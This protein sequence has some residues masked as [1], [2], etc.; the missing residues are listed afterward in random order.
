[1]ARRWA[2]WGDRWPA[3]GRLEGVSYSNRSN[4]T[5]DRGLGQRQIEK[6]LA[7][8]ETP[9]RNAPFEHIFD[10]EELFEQENNPIFC[11]DAKKKERL[12]RLYRDGR[13]WTTAPQQAFDHDFPSWSE[14]V[15]IPH[16][17]YDPQ[18][19]HGHVNIGLSHDTSQFACES[20]VWF[21]EHW[22]QEHYPD[23]EEILLECDAG[24]SN[25]CRH[26]ILKRT[27]SR[28]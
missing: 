1:M 22:G 27:C 18:L 12:G 6:S 8:G 23:A 9:D 25:N 28:P 13:V 7:G 3:S 5:E 4:R 16:G 11:M 17:I 20:L 19:N 10:L 14:G 21:W 2:R 15:I 26:K 24:G